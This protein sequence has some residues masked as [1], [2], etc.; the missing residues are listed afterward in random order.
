MALF[1]CC[2]LFLPSSSNFESRT[3]WSY[4]VVWD[5]A[6][7]AWDSGCCCYLFSVLVFSIACSTEVSSTILWMVVRWEATAGSALPRICLSSESR[8]LNF[9]VFGLLWISLEA[10]IRGVFSSLVGIFFLS[11]S[12]LMTSNFE[13]LTSLISRFLA[14]LLPLLEGFLILSRT[15]SPLK[16]NDSGLV[17][18][19]DTPKFIDNLVPTFFFFS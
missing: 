3:Y 7:D 16:F 11:F 14:V 15:W 1:R 18:F 12:S 17:V 9:W 4:S 5:Y 13:S 6:I 2:P 19:F 10:L 8:R